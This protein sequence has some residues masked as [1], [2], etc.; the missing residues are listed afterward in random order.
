[1]TVARRKILIFLGLLVLIGLACWQR[2]HIGVDVLG[3][4]IRALGPWG[5]VAYIFL[6]LIAPPLFIPGSVITLAGDALFGPL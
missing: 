1:M 2:S 5:P 4:R 3:Q 6:V